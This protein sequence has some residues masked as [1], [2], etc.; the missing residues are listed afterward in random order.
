MNTQE[1]QNLSVKK[2]EVNGTTLSY[3]EKGSGEPMVFI[4]GAVSDF[5]TWIEQ[6]EAFSADYRVISYSRRG[7]YP[8]DAETGAAQ[9]TRERHAADLI[10]FLKELDLKKAHLVGHSY[11]ASIALMAALENPELVGSLILGEPSPFPALFREEDSFL[12]SQ[13]KAGFDKAVQLAEIGN[14]ELAVREF[15]HTIVGIDAFGLLPEERRVVILENA[16]TLLP[17]LQNYY[18]SPMDAE[19]ISRVKTPT[20]LIT[21]EL[22]PLIVRISNKLID[23]L[24]PNSKIA[25]LKCASHGLQIENAE[26]FNQLV[27]D[28]LRVNK[29][30]AR[31]AKYKQLYDSVFH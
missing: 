9:Y 27:W 19:Q 14:Q 5:R 8:N 2:A 20:L 1:L 15:L 16:H 17:M 31:L 30:T 24:L 6:F 18:N 28:F 21:G 11:G 3:I 13:Q 4:H 23:R 7:H 22:S 10:G 25:V 26:G 12:L 29:N